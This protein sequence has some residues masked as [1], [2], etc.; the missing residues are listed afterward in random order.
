ME[1]F[2]SFS[3][4]LTL[5]SPCFLPAAS[6][7][8]I[9]ALEFLQ[10]ELHVCGHLCFSIKWAI[11]AKFSSL[12][13]SCWQTCPKKKLVLTVSSII[14]TICKLSWDYRRIYYRWWKVPCILS[15]QADSLKIFSGSWSGIWVLEPLAYVGSFLRGWGRGK[16]EGSSF[17]LCNTKLE[18]VWNEKEKK[19]AALSYVD[20]NMPQDMN[21]K[22]QHCMCFF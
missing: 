9:S 17:F 13:I 12:V 4:P 1:T 22:K 8:E 5:V 7:L 18:S 21:C 2:L 19:T 14:I 20:R 16:V 11:L 15:L 3:L 6:L 10:V